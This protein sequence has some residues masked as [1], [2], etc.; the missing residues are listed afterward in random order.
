[1]MMPKHIRPNP[2]THGKNICIDCY[3]AWNF[4]NKNRTC[5]CAIV[6]ERTK[7]VTECDDF[8]INCKHILRGT[9]VAD[10]INKERFTILCKGNCIYF[11]CQCRGLSCEFRI[12][13]E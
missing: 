5:W 1:M 2:K 11:N 8:L 7:C 13:L 3:H 10:T 4:S 6:K 12:I 9:F